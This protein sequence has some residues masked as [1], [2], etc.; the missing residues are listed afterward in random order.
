MR[1]EGLTA[2]KYVQSA[3]KSFDPISLIVSFG[4]LAGVIYS[5]V[6]A[7]PLNFLLDIRGLI[8]V[9]AGTAATLLFQFDF[10][11]AWRSLVYVCKTFFGTPDK[12]LVEINRL[13]NDAILNH[14]ALHDLKEGGELTGD[15][16]NDTVY[17][18]RSGLLFEEIDEF[19]T[20]RVSDEIIQRD[21][22]VAFLQRASVVAPS[23]GLF[24]TVIG[25]IGVLNNLTN[26]SQI[27]PSMSLALMT[28][29]YG[30]GLS[31]LVF[32]PLAGRLAH[33]NQVYLESHKQFL[34]KVAVL[35]HRQ[36]RISDD[37]LREVV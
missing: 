12:S 15:L 25:L 5:S 35:L 34:S 37:G 33:H 3:R 29:A 26:P 18:S 22:A 1:M 20:S 27:G 36:E 31:S 28:T 9:F 21:F 30:S 16:L 19:V 7:N 23:L 24:G 32:N 14:L 11:G 6:T 2:K 8:I 17:M 4:G 10:S 13:L